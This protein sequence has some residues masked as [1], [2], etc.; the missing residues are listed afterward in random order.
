MT[1]SIVPLNADELIEQTGEMT[2]KAFAFFRLVADLDPIV[3]TG[4]P[5]G[6]VEAR[7]PRFYVDTSGTTGTVLYVKLQNSILG[8]RTKGWVLV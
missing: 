6:S 8:D 1:Q 2:A 5:E 3:G 7:V 4:S